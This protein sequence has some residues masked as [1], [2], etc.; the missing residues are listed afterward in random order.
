MLQSIF[1]ETLKLRGSFY[2]IQS[3]V[4]KRS[5]NITLLHIIT[6][7][8]ELRYLDTTNKLTNKQTVSSHSKIYNHYKSITKTNN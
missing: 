8:T 7:F 1:N 2:E 6:Q 3:N 4:T 5:K